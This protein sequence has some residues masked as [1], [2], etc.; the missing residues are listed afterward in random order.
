V[1]KISKRTKAI[2]ATAALL[3]AIIAFVSAT[4]LMNQTSTA[5][6]TSSDE[7]Q[8]IDVLAIGKK[9]VEEMYGTDYELN[10]NVS[11][12]TYSNG[13][14]TWTYP[15]AYFRVPADWQKPGILVTVMVNPETGQIF[16]VL[17]SWSKNMPTPNPISDIKAVNSE[18]LNHSSGDVSKIFLVSSEPRYDFWTQNDTH[19]DWL[20]NGPVIHKGDPVFVVNASVRNDYPLNDEKRVD[21]GNRS[22]VGFTVALFDKDNNVISALQAYP[23]RVT[24]LNLS[25]FTVKSGETTSIELYYATGN[26]NID[27]YEILVAYVSSMVVP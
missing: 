14:G 4:I 27:H 13:T 19:M 9:Y 7:K 3:I 10:G 22:H 11:R 15:S 16:K 6:P 20:S 8:G 21:G 26:R 12:T 1:E 17:T 23:Q 25:F 2:L 5:S 24:Q 18:Y